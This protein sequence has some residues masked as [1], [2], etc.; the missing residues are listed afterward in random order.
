MPARRHGEQQ[1]GTDRCDGADRN[2]QGLQG[3]QPDQQ[4]G[5][6]DPADAEGQGIT[7]GASRIHHV[8]ERVVPGNVTAE[9]PVQHHEGGRHGNEV[10]RHH[11]GGV[12]A[13]AQ[14]EVV[15]RNDV[16]EVGH[17]QGQARRVG[18]ETGRHDERQGRRW[19]K[20]QCEQ[21]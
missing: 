2:A 6:N 12:L 18:N 13:E 20:T 17:H 5:Q 11:D 9:K 1:R 7:H 14:V 4:Q 16:D 10:D 19:R 15:G 21:Y 8:I 3:K